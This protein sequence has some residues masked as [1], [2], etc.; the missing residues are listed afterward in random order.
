MQLL[1]HLW[2]AQVIHC[3]SIGCIQG[4]Y[5]KH[6]SLLRKTELN[7]YHFKGVSSLVELWKEIEESEIFK[8][9]NQK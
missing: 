9:T 1:C 7:F 2:S 6:F 3:I 4:W 8:I 5:P